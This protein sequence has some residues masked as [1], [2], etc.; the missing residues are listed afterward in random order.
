MTSHGSE[1]GQA[2]RHHNAL[3]EIIRR[4][5]EPSDSIMTAITPRNGED[6]NQL[7]LLFPSNN[8]LM[9]ANY[10]RKTSSIQYL[11]NCE[12]GTPLILEDVQADTPVR[13]DVAVVDSRRE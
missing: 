9:T 7:Q 10:D 3:E 12:G 11:R 8:S 4:G 2:A 5:E 1:C 6:W 13:V